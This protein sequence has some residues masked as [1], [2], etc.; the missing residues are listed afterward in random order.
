[1]S[2]QIETGVLDD[3]KKLKHSA[4]RLAEISKQDVKSVKGAFLNVD[5]EKSRH[6]FRNSE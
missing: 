5:Y 2:K 3:P 4:L 6:V 1:M